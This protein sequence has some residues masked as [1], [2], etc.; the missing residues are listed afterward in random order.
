MGAGVDGFIVII[1][2]SLIVSASASS[3]AAS[4]SRYHHQ[5][6]HVCLSSADDGAYF[7]R[8]WLCV[9]CLLQRYEDV[10]SNLRESVGDPALPEPFPTRVMAVMVTI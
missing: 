9:A 3:S 7:G 4:P 1:A 8:A 6:G 5:Y 10:G 2:I